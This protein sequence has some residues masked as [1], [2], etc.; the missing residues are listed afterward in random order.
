MSNENSGANCRSSC[1]EGA[2]SH[3]P[4]ARPDELIQFVPTK[5]T[6]VA[7]RHRDKLERIAETVCD[8]E[9]ACEGAFSLAQRAARD[10]RGRW[11]GGPCPSVLGVSEE[12]GYR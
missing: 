4:Q 9:L 10:D 12:N 5:G 6:Q 2:G 11:G 1:Q 7:G 3:Q 8:L